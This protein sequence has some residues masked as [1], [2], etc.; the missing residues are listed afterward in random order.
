MSRAFVPWSIRSNLDKIPMVLFPN[1]STCLASFK[2]SEL[3]KST[4]AGETARMMEFGFEMYSKIKFLICLS[5]SVGWSPIGI[6]VRPGKS[7]I[8]KLRTFGE[9]TFKLIGILLIPLFLPAILA[10]SFSISFLMLS[11]L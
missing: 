4:L 1:G 6:F 5:I 2:D 10:V 8:V 7:T 11:K 9:Y 3:T